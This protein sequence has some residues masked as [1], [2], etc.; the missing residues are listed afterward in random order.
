MILVSCGTEKYPFNRLAVMVQEFATRQ[1]Q[2]HFIYQSRVMDIIPQGK[3]IVVQSMLSYQEFKMAI[4]QCRRCICHAGIG[5]I[6]T[7]LAEGVMPLVIP[8]R[9]EL[10]EHVDDHQ[11]QITEKLVDLGMIRVFHSLAELEALVAGDE[12][13]GI[14]YQFQNQPLLDDIKGAVKDWLE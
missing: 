3:N 14:R 4:R 12:Q 10:G 13:E 1:P 5:S 6:V 11:L 8:R 7:A 9:H 2:R